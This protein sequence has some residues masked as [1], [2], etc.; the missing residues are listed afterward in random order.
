[1]RYDAGRLH[2]LLQLRSYHMPVPCRRAVVKLAGEVMPG[3]LAAVGGMRDADDLDSSV[4][5]VREAGRA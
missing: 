3:H 2:V 1:M 4:T 5:A